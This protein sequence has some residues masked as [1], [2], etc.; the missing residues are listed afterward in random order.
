M[1]IC[2]CQIC[3]KTF[4]T[5]GS[6]LGKYCSMKCYSVFRKTLTGDKN[7]NFGTRLSKENRSKISET[8]KKY[9]L[10]NPSM[11]KGRKRSIECRMKISAAH[12]GKRLTSEHKQKISES[13]K[14]TL[15]SQCA[16]ERMSERAKI[17]LSDPLMRKKYSDAQKKRCVCPEERRARSERLKNRIFTEEHRKKLSLSETGDKNHR[18]GKK[19]TEETKLKRIESRVGGFWYGNVNYPEVKYCERWTKNLRDRVRA[20]FGYRCFECGIQQTYKKLQVHHV[21]YNKKTCCDGSPS[22]LVPLCDSC[23][24]KTCH[25]R[26]FWEGHFVKKLYSLN[27][28]GKC[29]FTKE[30]MRVYEKK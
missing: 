15:S 19:E 12:K 24:G 29:F 25:N 6:R 28:E 26:D 23:H 20:Y 9:Y 10:E 21:H 18:F 27:P 16:R 4:F 2:I 30:E 5:R 3:N 13:L 11:C 14:R 7:P 22:D 1:A 8:L 17:T